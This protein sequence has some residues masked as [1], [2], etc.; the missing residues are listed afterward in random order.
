[1]DKDRN[2]YVTDTELDDL[3]KVVYTDL[4]PYDLL[5]I[6]EMFLSTGSTILIDYRKFKE[7]LYLAIV[8]HQKLIDRK[9][10][11]KELA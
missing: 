6:I 7:Y 5:P 10:K 11:A 8:Q 1:M 9:K 4:K 2:G 3:M